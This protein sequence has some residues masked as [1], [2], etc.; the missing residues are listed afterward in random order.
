MQR[1]SVAL[2]A[3]A[4]AAGIVL[5]AASD[6]AAA[7]VV[8]GHAVSQGA[9]DDELGILAEHPDFTAGIIG[10]E[11]TAG[12]GSVSSDVSARWLTIRVVTTYAADE[13]ARLDERITDED[14]A[15]TGLADFPAF[16]QLPSD[17]RAEVLT[18][19]ASLRALQ[20]T[21]VADPD[22]KVAAATRAACPSG[23]FVSHILLATEAEAT[24]AAAEL[25]AGAPFGEVAAE[26]STD[27]GSAAQGGQLGCLDELGAAVAPFLAAAESIQVNVV[28]APVETEFGFHLIFVSDSPPPSDVD[29]ASVG[30]VLARI[31]RVPVEI[32]PRYGSWD[33]ERAQ[34]RPSSPAAVG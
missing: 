30:V 27:P 25:E 5:L 33:P 10:I 17:F 1:L 4:L 34:V 2:V 14:R 18:G 6:G 13:I 7:F 12:R 11:V 9:I 21:L 29:A 15:A 32:D 31:G 16:R 20:R 23:R 19:L 22:G 28:S 3:V 24:A 26:R 8:D